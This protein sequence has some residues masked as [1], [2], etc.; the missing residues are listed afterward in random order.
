MRSPAVSVVVPVYDGDP[1]L[2]RRCLESVW[3]QEFDDLELIVVDDGSHPPLA[4]LLDEM[5]ELDPRTSVIHQSNGGVSAARNT[6]VAASSG[7][8]IC[9]VDADDYLHAAFL[10]DA[11]AI[12][13]AHRC[14]LVLG[15]IRILRESGEHLWR[16]GGP[17]STNPLILPQERLR[18]IA[19][20]ILHS[21]P[22][23]DADAPLTT[24]TNVVAVL[25]ASELFRHVA[26]PVGVGHAEDRIFNV[27]ALMTAQK[28]AFCSDPWYTYD[29]TNADSVTRSLTIGTADQL[30]STI[31]ALA[32]LSVQG[33]DDG[34][35]MDG[36]HSS[37]QHSAA[38]GT[39]QYVQQLSATLAAAGTLREGAQYLRG[40]L[41]EPAI[42][43]AIGSARPTSAKSRFFKRLVS[44]RRARTV[45]ALMRLARTIDRVRAPLNR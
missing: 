27:G 38:L 30:N 11:L 7:R 42:A 37:L 35:A 6:G 44:A 31:R 9:F 40:V 3:S 21:S 25:Y 14:D 17:P 20:D 23:P 5:G 18:I 19:A 32:A 16:A 22:S 43:S 24:A 29:H 2:I 28:A 36:R 10:R 15:G 13:E 12:A 34:A 39:L 45:M 33:P 8:F 26:F 4:N 41:S 1:A